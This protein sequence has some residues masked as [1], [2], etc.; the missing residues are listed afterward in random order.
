MLSENKIDQY[1]LNLIL[2]KPSVL[3]EDRLR[4]LEIWSNFGEVN[5]KFTDQNVNRLVKEVA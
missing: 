3:H 5:V 1:D 4:A 2:A